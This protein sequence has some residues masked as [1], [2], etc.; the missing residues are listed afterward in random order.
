MSASRVAVVTGAAQGIGEAIAI[1][2]AADTSGIDVAVL[3][4]KGKEAQLG[5]LVKRIEAMGR[6]AVA[7]ICDVSS[8][9]AVRAAVD[10]TVTV[11]GGLDIM[12]ANAGIH[13]M[14]PLLEMTVEDWN[15]IQSVNVVGVMLC[16]KYAALQMIK[17]GRG[18]RLVAACSVAGKRAQPNM[19]AYD[20]SKFAVRGLTQSAALE[21]RSHGITVNSYAPG[22]IRTPMSDFNPH[23][24]S[25]NIMHRLSSLFCA[26]AL[27]HE[28]EKNS[29]TDNSADSNVD[30]TSG[31]PPDIPSAGPEVISELVA[32]FVKPEAFFTTGQSV[33]VDG[34]AFYFD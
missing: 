15:K 19:S 22:A 24:R 27:N 20:C 10:K 14:S 2:L 26:S 3:D 1:R 30:Q 7:I 29:D 8:E 12:V 11:L 28:D 5:D 17:Q 34:G 23:F 9:E 6:K 4:V 21:W 18:G 16:Y 32:Y 33:V 25:V 13:T 31:L